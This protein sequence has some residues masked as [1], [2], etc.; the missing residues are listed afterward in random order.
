MKNIFH[1]VDVEFDERV[2]VVLGHPY[3]HGRSGGSVG[4]GAGLTLRPWRVDRAG[5]Q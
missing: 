2:D 3:K 5:W 4:G 1:F